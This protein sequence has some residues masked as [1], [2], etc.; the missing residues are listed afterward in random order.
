MLSLNEERVVYKAELNAKVDAENNHGGS[1][2]TYVLH[3]IRR[4]QED[5]QLLHQG[6]ERSG[7]PGRQN[8]SDAI[9]AGQLDDEDSSAATF[10]CYG[11]D[12]FTGWIYDRLLP[13]AEQVKVTPPDAV[14][15]RNRREEK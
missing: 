15:H 2:E 7:P 14:R 10:H 9:R 11:D 12:I 4:S 5:H 3:R 13:H 8:R 6:C 1:S